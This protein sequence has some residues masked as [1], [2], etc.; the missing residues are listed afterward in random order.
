MNL[1]QE[2]DAE[3]FLWY[4]QVVPARVAI[5]AR[6]RT[7]PARLAPVLRQALS[8]V[9]KELPLARM[10]TMDQIVSDSISS[11]RLTT[12]L[13]GIFAA[14]AMILAAVGVY[15][16]IS[17][18]VTQRTHEIGIRRA[19]GAKSG[20]VLRTVAGQPLFLAGIGEITGI[21]ASY[22]FR[23]VIDSELYGSTSTD[24]LIFFTVPALLAA[25]AVMAAFLASRRALRIDPLLAL[26]GE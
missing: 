26:R 25:V 3:A 17:Y 12:L 8:S 20:D 23:H 14:V 11:R 24:P 6:A 21:G 13:L 7:D 2:P 10:M 16:I 19:M 22:A 4:R 1:T 9:D 18:S 5:V 15:G